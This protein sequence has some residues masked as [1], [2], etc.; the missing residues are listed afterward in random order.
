MVT[1][2]VMLNLAYF[3]VGRVAGKNDAGLWLLG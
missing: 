2:C 1:C 3:G